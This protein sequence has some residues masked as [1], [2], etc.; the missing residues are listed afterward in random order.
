MTPVIGDDKLRPAS[1]KA[2]LRQ[3]YDSSYKH[4][5]G[6]RGDWRGR[7]E[8]QGVDIYSSIHLHRYSVYTG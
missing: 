2:R 4:T 8:R 3:H 7:L 5:E 1:S 6:E